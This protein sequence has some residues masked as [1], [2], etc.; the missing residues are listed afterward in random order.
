MKKIF[1][2]AMLFLAACTMTTG[3]TA[4]SDD[5][6]DNNE[7]K[8][9]EKEVALQSLTNQYV[10]NVVYPTYSNLATQTEQLYDLLNEATEKFK[11][12]TLAQSDI[13]KICNVFLSARAY[14]EKSEA[15]L[16]GAAT[17]FGID[18]HIDT[19]PLDVKVLANTLKDAERIADLEGEDGIEYAR[20]SLG[21][22]LLG[23]HGIEFI[24]FRDGKN[25]TVSA[26]KANE[27]DENFNGTNVNG[28]Q[29]LIYAT[30]IAGDLR[31]K[32]YQLEVSWMGEAAPKSH[33][34]RVEECEFNLTVN[35]VEDLYYGKNILNAAKAGSTYSSWFNVAYTILVAGCSNIA[36]E[37]A[38]Q[39]MGQAYRGDDVN[40]IESPYSKKSFVDFYDNIVSIKNSLYGNFDK[41]NA[42]NA[43]LMSY[44]NKYNSTLANE[45]QTS[46]NDALAAL[47]NCINSGTA[48]V[49]RP[50]AP[51]VKTAMDAI[52]ELDD[53]LNEAA[54]WITRNH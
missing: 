27:T 3:F 17:D 23:F 29:E 20:A 4:C 45:L 36:Q 2:Y 54:T 40:Y 53:K 31:D 8:L 50:N 12:N 42:E 33:F 25:R 38:D 48:F 16:Y 41:D 13:D 22:Q 46:L 18:P 43:S 30:A 7:G 1:K 35:G 49:D 5:D 11:N 21:E 10:N 39:K 47:N 32:C 24:I 52:G 6:D 34:E 37:V 26:L 44:L 14:W 19:W 15:F 28:L 51:H 9:T